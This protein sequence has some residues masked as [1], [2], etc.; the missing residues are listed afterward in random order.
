MK[1]KLNMLCWI[2]ILVM[3]SCAH[4]KD[5]KEE[6]AIQNQTPEV[7]DQADAASKLASISK[8]YS[9]DIIQEL[10]DEA[11]N[12]DPELKSL[13]ENIDKT[14]KSTIDSLQQYNTYIQ[15]NNSYWSAANDY[16]SQISDSTTKK[17]MKD[18]F[19]NLKANHDNLISQHKVLNENITKSEVTLND[20]LILMKL[21]VTEP[22]MLNY[23]RNELPDIKKMKG[24]L[25]MY[26][27]LINRTESYTKFTK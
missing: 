19:R 8:R 6:P 15:N 5:K 23:Q 4:N 17:L 14:G 21:L 25:N 12:K 13:V 9:N 2:L 16:I 1:N 11:I 20:H 10:F 18:A 7:L 24:V 3:C 27:T 26:D 22:M